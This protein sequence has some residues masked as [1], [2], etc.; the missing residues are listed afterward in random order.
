MVKVR[1]TTYGTLNK[2][3]A[4]NSHEVTLEQETVTVEDVLRSAE[5]GDGTTLF[6]LVAYED[7]ISNNHTILLNGRPLWQSKDLKMTIKEGD[8]ISALDILF[9]IGGG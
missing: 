3:V 7:G 2:R 9:A 6:D 5:L 4:W 8:E 1:I